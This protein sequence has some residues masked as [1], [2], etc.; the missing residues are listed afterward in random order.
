MHLGKKY[1]RQRE[2]PTQRP[3]SGNVP[4]VFL[5][6]QGDKDEWNGGQERERS[7]KKGRVSDRQICVGLC[8]STRGTGL[9]L[10]K[11]ESHGTVLM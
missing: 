9:I 3:Q 2:N 8:E 5:D 7:G 1:Y 4:N 6:Q 10:S 11:M